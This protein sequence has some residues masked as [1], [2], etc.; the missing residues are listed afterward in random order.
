MEN[1]INR[2]ERALRGLPVDRTPIW[3]MRQAGRYLPEYREVRKRLSFEQMLA[4]ADVA[5][6]ITLQPVK[7]FDLDAAVIFADIMTILNG[8]D[9]PFSFASGAPAL[10]FHIQD[11]AD[12]AKLDA[13]RLVDNLSR[14][15]PFL[16][17][18]RQTRAALPPEKSVLGFAASPFTL[19]SYLL[20]GTTSKTHNAARA[21]M[22]G[23]AME[24][25]SLMEGI[26]D[27]TI[28]YLRLQVAAGASAVQIFESWGDVLSPRTYEEYILPHVEKIVNA[29]SPLAP[30]IIYDKGASLHMPVLRPFI[31][32]SGAILS[33]DWRISLAELGDLKIQGNLDPAALESEPAA[34]RRET[35][36]ILDER[37]G[38]PGHVFNL[39]HGISPHAKLAC[40]EA[41]VETVQTYR[42]SLLGY[43]IP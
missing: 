2:F 43:E 27:C 26:A 25:H 6:E 35:A 33:V 11:R 39:G 8:L 23:L 15:E 16:Q 22:L 38:R 9:I 17:T 14:Y 36:R 18:I 20:E 10:E 31:L 24:F 41:M 1:H 40:V 21:F 4:D 5:T 34:V 19:L 3:F 13:R 30:V 29:I 42:T 37:G 28:E 7:R 12:W 32:R